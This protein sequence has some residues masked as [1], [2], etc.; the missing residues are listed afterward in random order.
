MLQV[1]EPGWFALSKFTSAGLSVVDLA[2]GFRLS[3]T[4]MS[5]FEAPST[6]AFDPSLGVAEMVDVLVV[7]GASSVFPMSRTWPTAATNICL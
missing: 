6:L 2:R 1:P 5:L 7:E 3:V 4:C